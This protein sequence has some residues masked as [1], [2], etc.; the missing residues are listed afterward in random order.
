MQTIKEILEGPKVSNYQ[1]SPK[2]R[3]MVAQQ[4]SKIWGK[5]EV[6][7]YSPERNALPFSVWFRLGY[8]PKRGSKALKSVTY[9]ERKDAL[10]NIIQRYPRKIN[11]YYYKSVEPITN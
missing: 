2:T 1:N 11:L 4:I 6:K 10:G 8:R 3:K 5:D 7:N 9:I